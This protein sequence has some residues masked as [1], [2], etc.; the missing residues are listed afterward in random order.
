[1]QPRNPLRCW[2]RTWRLPRSCWAQAI[3]FSACIPPQLAVAEP[4]RSKKLFNLCPELSGVHL[5]H[6]LPF[7]FA[8]SHVL[9]GSP[10][11]GSDLVFSCLNPSGAQE[12]LIPNRA[13]LLGRGN[14]IGSLDLLS[15]YRACVCNTLWL[16]R[17]AKAVSARSLCTYL[18][19]MGRIL[20]KT[21]QQ[22]SNPPML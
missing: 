4:L 19:C 8:A 5:R 18:G 12:P 21:A 7:F 9:Q 11:L 17:A 1:M 22:P 14:S 15:I 13:A 10:L 16:S 20:Q 6:H 2:T 3:P